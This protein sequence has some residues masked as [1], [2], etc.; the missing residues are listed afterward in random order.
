MRR[1]VSSMLLGFVVVAMTACSGAVKFQVKGNQATAA[2]ADAVVVADIDQSN[3]LTKLNFRGENLPPPSRIDKESNHFVLWA[4]KDAN[5]QWVR[6]GSLTYDP[7]SRK[8]IFE[9]TASEASFD[10]QLTT[11]KVPNPTSPSTKVVFEQRVQKN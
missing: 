1:F 6:V 11:E 5:S 8:G 4:R 2:G 9:G 3:A 7:E 10:L